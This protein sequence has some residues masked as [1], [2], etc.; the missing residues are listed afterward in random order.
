MEK[1]TIAAVSQSQAGTVIRISTSGE[2]LEKVT[3]YLNS[4]VLFD[5]YPEFSVDPG[6]RNCPYC[7]IPRATLNFCAMCGK[8]V[9]WGAN[10]GEEE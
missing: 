6:W 8:E 7:Q 4:G 2:D 5:D 10:P 9:L 1:K 3:I